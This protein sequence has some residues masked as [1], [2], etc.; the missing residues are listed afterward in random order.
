MGE[1]WHE[2]ILRHAS[3]EAEGV[4][5]KPELFSNALRV[6]V[7]LFITAGEKFMVKT[8]DGTYYERAK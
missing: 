4:Y 2:A 5:N 7:L 1:V 8:A 6:I 3:R